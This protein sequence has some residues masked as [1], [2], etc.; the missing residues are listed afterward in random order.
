MSKRQ[1]LIS[2]LHQLLP[3]PSG[4]RHVHNP[5]DHAKSTEVILDSSVLSNSIKLHQTLSAWP[6]KYSWNPS[7]SLHLHNHYVG[8]SSEHL[9]PNVSPSLCAGPPVFPPPRSPASSQSELLKKQI[10]CRRSTH[11]HL[12]PLKTFPWVPIR[13]GI[14]PESLP[15]PEGPNVIWPHSFSL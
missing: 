4:L 1:H 6:L 9:S 12:H 14:K 5:V 8:P 10:K 2:Y 3:Q 15:Q 11:T 7:P 13:L